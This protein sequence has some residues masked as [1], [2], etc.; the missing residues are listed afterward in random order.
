MKT[1]STKKE[2]SLVEYKTIPDVNRY[3]TGSLLLSV[4]VFPETAPEVE[5]NKIK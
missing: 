3:L 1:R 5:R 4:S 2:K